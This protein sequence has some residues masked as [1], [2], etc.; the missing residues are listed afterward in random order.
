[1]LRRT[2][3]V[4]P[5]HADPRAWRLGTTAAAIVLGVLS[6]GACI[7]EMELTAARSTRIARPWAVPLEWVGPFRAVNG[8]GLFRVMTRE[9]PEIVV[10]VSAD[11]Q[12]WWEYEFRWKAGHP[13]RR[14]RL[15]A[16]H[17]PRLDWQMW[18]AA[19]HPPS[20]R[21]WLDRLTQQILAGEPSVL[22]LLGSSPLVNPPRYVRLAY[23]DYEFASAAE[24]AT[25]GAWW[26]R[27]FVSY[28]NEPIAAP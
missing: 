8:Y 16:P 11:G 18:F 25:T 13:L 3:G 21:Y 6:L 19:L 26:R 9:R 23:Y 17:M 7:R 28:L 15:V 14:P 22:R 12:N 2:G 24:R 4:V 5:Q 10:E 1:M 27:R 20:A